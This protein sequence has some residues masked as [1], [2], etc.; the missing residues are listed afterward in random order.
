[1]EFGQGCARRVHQLKL[2]TQGGKLKVTE[3]LGGEAVQRKTQQKT[4]SLWDSARALPGG[5]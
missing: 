4:K 2:Q 1:M 3:Y 5:H